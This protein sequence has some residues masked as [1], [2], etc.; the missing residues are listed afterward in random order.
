MDIDWKEVA[1]SS[2][3]ISM[4]A[5]VAAEATRVRKFKHNKP[6]KRYF[7]AFNFAINRAK[8]YAHTIGTS[9]IFVLN[10]WEDKRK[11]N[12]INYCSNYTFPRLD[13]THVLKPTGIN[14][15]RNRYKR[16]NFYADRV[17]FSKHFVCE[18]I[19]RLGRL[20]VK[21]SGRKPRWTKEYKA[22]MQR[23]KKHL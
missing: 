12:F 3:Y 19:M 9:L 11:Y 15:I 20:R 22:R 7:E 21:E 8:H 18:E 4:K 14:G 23:Y 1:A 6:D 13:C 17:K 5:A 2:G 16:Y 10:D